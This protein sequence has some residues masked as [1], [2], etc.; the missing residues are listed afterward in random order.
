MPHFRGSSAQPL[1]LWP[2]QVDLNFNLR[3]H[4]RTMIIHIEGNP[5]RVGSIQDELID[6]QHMADFLD[7]F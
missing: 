7:A 3:G 6:N 1:Y 4:R 5:D 2:A